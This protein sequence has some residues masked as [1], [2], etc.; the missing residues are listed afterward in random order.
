MR[1]V[2]VSRDRVLIAAAKMCGSPRPDN[3]IL[4]WKS[5]SWEAFTDLLNDGFTDL[6]LS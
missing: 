3:H 5:E 2:V 1:E 4:G 6:F